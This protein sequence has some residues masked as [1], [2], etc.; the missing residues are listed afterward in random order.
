M[1]TFLYFGT[2]FYF[3]NST[4][5]P[6]VDVLQIDGTYGMYFS[7]VTYFDARKL[8]PEVKPHYSQYG[9]SNVYYFVH[10]QKI[11]FSNASLKFLRSMQ[12]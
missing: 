3:L 6:E 5:K 8:S 2:Q 11:N 9:E 4:K 7:T 10:E 12:R 1:A